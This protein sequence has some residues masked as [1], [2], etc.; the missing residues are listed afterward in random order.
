MRVRALS[1]TGDYTFGRSQ[2]N[3]LVDSSAAVAQLIRTNLLL[4]QGEW[5]LDQ[6]YGMPWSQDVL[7]VGTKSIYDMVIQANVLATMAPYQAQ[8]GQAGSITSYSSSLQGR[9]L[10]VSMTVATPFSAEPVTINTEF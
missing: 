5:F 1:P 8:T 9:K 4:W 2:G 10:S 3:F 7:G 6:T